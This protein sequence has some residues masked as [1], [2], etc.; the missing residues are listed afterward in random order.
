MRA[1]SPF[2]LRCT[3]LRQSSAQPMAPN[4][5]VTSSTTQTKRFV[6]LP[7]RSVVT[8]I[9]TRISAPPIVG[10]PA[11]DRCVCGPSSRTDWPI[12]MCASHAIIRGPTTNEMTSAV[13]VASTA[14]NVM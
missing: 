1:D 5:A 6:R 2:G 8:T 13:I 9:E 11:L 14:R 10:V 3:T 4:P 12:F 7:H